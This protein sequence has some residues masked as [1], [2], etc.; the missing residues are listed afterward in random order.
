V[1]A[2]IEAGRHISIKQLSA[3]HM[4]PFRTISHILHK[5]LGLLKK[6]SSGVSKLL[7]LEHD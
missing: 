5:E 1:A 7:S 4:T 2:A 6:L 3:V